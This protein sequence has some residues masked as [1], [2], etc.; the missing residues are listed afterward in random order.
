MIKGA[1]YSKKIFTRLDSGLQLSIAIICKFSPNIKQPTYTIF[2][3]FP[4]IIFKKFPKRFSV[5]I[6]FDLRL[7]WPAQ[8]VSKPRGEDHVS[9][10]T[11][12]PRTPP[13][14][15][16]STKPHL[17]DVSVLFQPCRR[18]RRLFFTGS[19]CRQSSQFSSDRQSLRRGLFA[20]L[21][22]CCILFT[23]FTEVAAVATNSRW[24]LPTTRC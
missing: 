13:W 16:L 22:I 20:E 17:V 8:R 7:I 12:S 19:P 3:T 11:S 15:T 24:V 18:C 9:N 10:A 5:L 1:L 2:K 14:T 6:F 23:T 4:T 21:P